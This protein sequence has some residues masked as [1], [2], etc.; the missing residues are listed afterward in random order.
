MPF[1]ILDHRDTQFGPVGSKRE[2]YSKRFVKPAQKH[3]NV[4]KVDRERSFYCASRAK[5]DKGTAYRENAATKSTKSL[6]PRAGTRSVG[7]RRAR[8]DEQ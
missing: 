1:S 8:K 3:R 7:T 2:K 6:R 4:S 5:I